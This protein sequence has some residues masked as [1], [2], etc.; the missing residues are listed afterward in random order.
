MQVAQASEVS[1]LD[2]ERQSTLLIPA[3]TTAHLV[4]PDGSTQ[5]VERPD[6]PS[7]GVQRWGE[8]RG[9]D[10]GSAAFADRLHLLRRFLC[11]R[12]VAAGADVQF[13]KP[14]IHYVENFLGFPVGSPVPTGSFDAD[15]NAWV[16]EKSGLVVKILAIED[17]RAVLDL[18]GSGESGHC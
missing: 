14:L 11:R 3:G 13:D 10:A 9:R 6:H 16:G 5:P 7:D 8:R 12:G 4:M 15:L 17:G 2:G 1:D 18:D